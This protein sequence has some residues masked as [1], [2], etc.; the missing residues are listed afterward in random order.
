MNPQVS[1][2]FKIRSKVITAMREYLD[3]KEFIEVETPT[4]QP[5][6][7]GA[8]A[9]PFITHHNSLNMRLYLRISNELYL[10]RLLVGGFEKVYEFVKDFRNEGID[11]S[12]NPEF[13]QVEFY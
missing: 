6:Y 1:E 5:I 8:N 10:K 4:L 9:K 13:T 3:K 12:H 7:G 2:T 11:T